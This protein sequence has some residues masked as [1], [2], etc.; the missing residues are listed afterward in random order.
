MSNSFLLRDIKHSYIYAFV[1]SGDLLVTADMVKTAS[2]R[3]VA[4]EA[5]CKFCLSTF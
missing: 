5:A 2:F 3:D 1:D 4:V